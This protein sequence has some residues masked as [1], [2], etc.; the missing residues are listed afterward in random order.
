MNILVPIGDY[1]EVSKFAALGDVEFFCGYIPEWWREKYNSR[2][3]VSTGK[4]ALPINNRYE[5]ASSFGTAGELRK[6]VERAYK[7]SCPLYLTL[8]FKYYPEF[9]YGDIERFIGEVSENGVKKLIVSDL[10]LISWL[11]RNHP[12]MDVSVSC[13]SQVTNSESVRFF[14]DFSNV[15]RIVFPRH[16]MTCEIIRIAEEFPE[17]EFEYFVFSNKCFYDDGYCRAVHEFHP[18]CRDRFS[19]EFKDSRGMIYDDYEAN[20]LLEHSVRT[21]R[22]W[23]PENTKKNSSSERW[24]NF[25]CSACSLSQTVSQPNIK[26]VKL[27]IRGKTLDERLEQ[28]RIALAAVRMA[29]ISGG[30]KE[31]IK[32]MIMNE[33]GVE[34]CFSGSHCMM[35]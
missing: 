11:S 16:M 17:M 22:E 29:K 30:D 27:S 5:I 31:K 26:A 10:G 9:V 12:E 8:N 14:S 24:Q 18:I 32:R 21:F 34:I 6:V 23:S 33:T 1:E 28:T 20:R 25:I 35:Q 3:L 13:L 2:E 15:E 19:Y 7:Y 4:M